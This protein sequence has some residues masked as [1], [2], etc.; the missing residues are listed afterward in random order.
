[1]INYPAFAVAFR[2]TLENLPVAYEGAF[3]GRPE[4]TCVPSCI[5]STIKM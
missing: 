5:H 3:V 4:A 2:M 1:M